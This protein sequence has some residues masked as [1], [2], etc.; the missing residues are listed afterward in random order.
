[1]RANSLYL[2]KA[3]YAKESLLLLD[4]GVVRRPAL[5]SFFEGGSSCMQTETNIN[6]KNTPLQKSMLDAPTLEC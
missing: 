4:L 3:L 6:N 1:M 5:L 2:G